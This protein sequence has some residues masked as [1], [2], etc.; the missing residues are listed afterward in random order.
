MIID[1][2]DDDDDLLQTIAYLLWKKVIGRSTVV[3]TV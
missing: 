3:A 1:D 2:D